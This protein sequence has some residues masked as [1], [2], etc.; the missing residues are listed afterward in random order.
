MIS[1]LTSQIHKTS[2]TSSTSRRRSSILT[3]LT[4]A[5]AQ[6]LDNTTKV[7][8]HEPFSI[9]AVIT[10]VIAHQIMRQFMTQY[11]PPVDKCIRLAT[12][13]KRPLV[14]LLKV[15]V[16]TEDAAVAIESNR[17]PRRVEEDVHGLWVEAE[18]LADAFEKR[19]EGRQASRVRL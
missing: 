4:L 12:T 8:H 1:A 6:K 16:V 17:F 5:L 9:V 2:L 15:K 19:G 11:D 14:Q 7:L 18:D 10:T 13:G 3:T